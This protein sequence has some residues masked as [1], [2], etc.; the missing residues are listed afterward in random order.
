MGVVFQEWFARHDTSPAYFI[1]GILLLVLTYFAFMRKEEYVLF[2]TGFTAMGSEML[3]IFVF[4]VLYGYVYLQIGLI[5]TASLLGLLPGAIVGKGWK[6]S[7]RLK[8]LVSEVA[9]IFL[10]VIFFLWLSCF[11]ME[12]PPFLFLVFCF[13]FSFFCGFQFPVTTDI[14]G[15]DKSP[16]ARCLAADLCGA[17]VGTLV[18]GAVVIPI[19]GMEYGTGFLILMKLSSMAVS[20][21]SGKAAVA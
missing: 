18:T 16:A 8:L 10:L 2:T 20:F 15:E 21:K 1:A 9:M 5:I 3:I 6:R 14:I 17:A 19:W 7:G 11:G 13:L 4:Q 12:P